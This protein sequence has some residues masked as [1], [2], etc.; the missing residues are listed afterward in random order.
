MDRIRLDK[1][2]IIVNIYDQRSEYRGTPFESTL[3]A[4]GSNVRM[5]TDWIPAGVIGD[6]Y[7]DSLRRTAFLK[8]AE[9]VTTWVVYDDEP[10]DR[11]LPPALSETMHLRLAESGTDQ[12]CILDLAIRY[13]QLGDVTFISKEHWEFAHNPDATPPHPW[14]IGESLDSWHYWITKFK[15]LEILRSMVAAPDVRSASALRDDFIDLWETHRESVTGHTN[16]LAAIQLFQTEEITNDFVGVEAWRSFAREHIELYVNGGLKDFC[17]AH[18]VLTP[19]PSI[20]LRGRG[21]VAAGLNSFAMSMLPGAG[22]PL[23]CPGCGDWFLAKHGKARHCS[24]SCK[25]QAYRKRRRGI[26]EANDGD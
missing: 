23:K 15:V 9:G 13:G 11:P 21:V 10:S 26:K 20:L 5:A 2:K 6:S 18:L 7:S 25:T 3:I 1:P 24:D 19:T 16:S 4:P 8:D 12:D 17:A 22:V 14:V